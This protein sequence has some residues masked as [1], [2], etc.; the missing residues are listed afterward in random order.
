[1]CFNYP[2]SKLEQDLQRKED[3]INIRQ[4]MPTASPQLQNRSFHF[5]ERTIA[6]AKC[7][8]MKIACAKHA[9][10]LFFIVKYANLWRSLCR[11][12]RAW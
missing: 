1:M 10:L 2:G 3:K 5:V 8:E 12:C 6:S 4:G 11:R 9:K 7:T